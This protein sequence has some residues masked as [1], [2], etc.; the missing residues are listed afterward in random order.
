MHSKVRMIVG[1]P[2]SGK[3]TYALNEQFGI[4]FDDPMKFENG[5]KNLQ[6]AL[7]M[8]YDVTITDIYCTDPDIRNQAESDL[9]MWG[10][11]EIEWMFFENNPQDC[12]WNITKRNDG[13]SI[14][15]DYVYELSKH[16]NIPENAKILP[17]WKGII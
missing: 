17:V 8:N 3:T 13:R 5:K 16:Y 6:L 15:S 7:K 12:I 2:G 4:L 14:S 10:A 11:T 1:L 9:H